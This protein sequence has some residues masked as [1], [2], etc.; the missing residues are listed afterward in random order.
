MSKIYTKKL[1]TQSEFEE[2]ATLVVIDKQKNWEPSCKLFYKQSAL[3]AI[4]M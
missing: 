1:C 2:T 4:R 3:H